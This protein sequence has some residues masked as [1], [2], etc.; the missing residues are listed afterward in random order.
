MEHWIPVYRVIVNGRDITPHM[1]GCLKNLTITKN[2][3]LEADTL[4]L[5][6]EDSKGELPLPPHGSVVTVALGYKHIGLIHQGDYIIDEV[7]HAGDPDELIIRARSADLRA[8]LTEG[9]PAQRSRSWHDKTIGDIVAAIAGE[10]GL[11]PK[12]GGSLGGIRIKHIDQT[13]ESDAHFLTRLGE[14]YDALFAVKEGKLLFIPIGQGITLSGQ[15]LPPAKVERKEGN[16]HRYLSADRDN[17]TGVVAYWNNVSG[18]RRQKVTVGSTAKARELGETYASEA[19]ATHAAESELK[20]L[21]RAKTNFSVN[22]ARANLNL[23]P[24]QPLTLQGYKPEIDR[25]EW[26]IVRVIH[27]LNDGGLV[28]GVDTELRI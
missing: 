21:Q 7:E 6:L 9:M 18:G 11:Q 28:S 17:Y 13:H 19:D 24:E 1:N 5:V 15:A 2:R 22:L 20:R 12:V 27:H 16:S 10:Y 23:V 14:R 3:H 8:N 4:N 25:E 26:I